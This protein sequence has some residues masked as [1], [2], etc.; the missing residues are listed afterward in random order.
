MFKSL[1]VRRTGLSVLLI[2]LLA[3][4]CGEKPEAMLSS[5]KEFIA[6]KDNKAA[7]IQIKNYL[8]KAPDNA[9]A[10][11][12]LG[13]ALMD[14]GDL[15]SAEVELRK[16]LELKYSADAVVPPL[17]SVM[18]A[19]GQAKKLVAEFASLQLGA[20][21]SQADLLSS[22]AL[23]NA[24]LG[25]TAAFKNLVAAALQVK[26]DHIPA[27]VL[28]ARIKG[29]AKDY[30]GAQKLI[31]QVLAADPKTASAWKLKGDLA[32]VTQGGEAG[33]EH[34]RKAVE[35][36]PEFV[37]GHAA[38]VQV[39]IREKKLDDAGNQFDQMKK[40]APRNPQTLFLGAQLAYL[41]KEFKASR[42]YLQN[43]HKLTQ[44]TPLSLQLAGAIDFATGAFASAEENLTKALQMSPDLAAARLTL[45]STYLQM[46]QPAKA[47]AALKPIL[48]KIEGDANFLSLAGA[49]Y[50]QL[51]DLKRAEDYYGKAAK[52]DP[53]DSTKRTR[54][55]LAH[56]AKGDPDALDELEDIA[57]ADSGIAANLALVNAYLRRNLVDKALKAAEVLAKKS[58]NDAAV[59]HLLGRA[60]I[61]KKD[62]VA[63]RAAFEKA[64]SLNPAFFPAA[65]SLAALDLADKKPEEARRRF[66]RVI[67]ADEKNVQAMLA[68]AGIVSQNKGKPEE[69]AAL[70]NKAIAVTPLDPSPRLVLIEEYLKY[71][72]PKKAQTV[73][74][75]ALA[76]IPDHPDL[77]LASGRVQLALGDHNQALLSFNKA[78]S[79]QPTSGVPYFRIAQVQLEQNDRPAAIRS[80][81]KA[82]DIKADYLEAQ[83]VLAVVLVQVDRY[84]EAVTLSRQIQ[85][86]RPKDAVGFVTEGDVAMIKKRWPD[87]IKAYRAGL[88]KAGATELAI[89]L[90]SALVSSGDKA[91]AEKFSEDWRKA[92]P[93]DVRFQ[94]FLAD[95]A[96]ERQDFATA[97]QHY[98]SLLKNDSNSPLILNNL[99]WAL[100]HL[101]DPKAIEY[102]EKANKLSPDQPPFMD[103]LA[104]LLAEKGDT[105]RAVELLRKALQLA[106]QAG[107]I[108][109]SLAKVL[110]Q[111]G[112]KAEARK[113]LEALGKLGNNFPAQAEVAKLLKEI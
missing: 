84:D 111:A 63:A 31:D 28:S 110:V 42:E 69:V 60:W 79:L 61:A 48:G 25:D 57:A 100:G 27:L 102:A 107:Q 76:A 9:E 7:I 32:Q 29:G 19:R 44:G 93:N 36:R 64:A 73:A 98:Q 41:K 12:L 49:V 2:A 5:A 26:P 87:A 59:V 91:G 23:A 55:A 43:F 1:P 11:F 47:E 99:A 37:S 30:D 92:N 68:I 21:A 94:L 50:D 56:L 108:R 13:K 97:V 75:N 86:Q 22:L 65:A 104:T 83:Q 88:E 15:T 78:A 38:I 72:E 16:A 89:K 80:L 52:L 20:P 67:A 109:L 18:L 8:Q 90:L 3:A 105:A 39:L 14:V 71:R 58:P 103:T 4:G 113:E 6:K 33:L 24:Y 34:Y 35:A 82:I 81:R 74:Q 54:L 101:K 70:L 66:E 46:G 40:A 17:A 95:W 53:S 77:L 62:L 85:K 96:A 45:I 51:G 10:R 112:Q 106:P